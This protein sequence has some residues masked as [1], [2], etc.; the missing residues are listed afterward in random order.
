MNN[1]ILY[2]LNPENLYKAFNLVMPEKIIDFSAQPFLNA[3]GNEAKIFDIIMAWNLLDIS[4]SV[5]AK[6][7]IFLIY[8]GV[9]PEKIIEL[10]SQPYLNESG[11]EAKNFNHE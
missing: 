9:N 4:C 6:I 11:N 10:S 2:G 5:L 1:F 3:S 7:I 8:Y